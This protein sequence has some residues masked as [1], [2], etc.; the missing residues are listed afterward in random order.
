MDMNNVNLIGRITKDLE[1]KKAGETVVLKFSLAVNRMKKDEADFITCTAFGK[2]AE[3]MAQY[4]GK[5]QQTAIQG[6]IQTG[7]YDK[8]G[9]TIYTTDVIVDK[10]FFIGNT[11]SNKKEETKVAGIPNDYFGDMQEVDGDMP[12]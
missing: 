11:A 6:H 12:F 8:E 10:F 1:L 9:T 2:T 5:G 7:K 3:N 4:L